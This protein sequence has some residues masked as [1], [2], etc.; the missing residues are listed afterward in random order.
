MWEW[1][2]SEITQ[3]KEKL[4]SLS[5]NQAKN[6][7]YEYIIDSI[8]IDK[9]SGELQIGKLIKN[10]PETKKSV[11]RFFINQIEIRQIDGDGTVGIGLTEK[12]DGG[13]KSSK[14]IKPE[15]A[16]GKV[17]KI[18]DEIMEAWETDEI[19]LFFQKVATNEEVL[20]KVWNYYNDISKYDWYPFLENQL[21]ESYQHSI[22]RNIAQ[23]GQFQ[24]PQLCEGFAQAIR[25]ESRTM[26]LIYVLL[27]HF[28]PNYSL[29][30]SGVKNNKQTPVIEWPQKLTP[31]FVFE[32]IKQSYQLKYLPQQILKLS[33]Y[34]HFIVDTFQSRMY[35]FIDST[36]DQYIL[37]QI[38]AQMVQF[39][40]SL[41]P[42]L[43]KAEF[44]FSLDAE[45]KADFIAQ[46]I[47]GS[48]VVPI[49]LLLY[50]IYHW[51]SCPVVN[52]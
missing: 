13:K 34:P 4:I 5:R 29:N 46:L 50:T 43:P 38:A 16:Q 15:E 28:F 47:W 27:F 52:E 6:N 49:H 25:A 40:S 23:T 31:E 18:Y 42:T 22:M 21:L 33:D 17:K 8:K 45:E 36:K 3:I 44:I 37:E 24:I 12:G 10:E 7:V 9:V 30:S 14:L 20:E 11:H 48:Q 35:P 1:I 26:I 2:Y 32:F 39:I 19:P 41:Y 51:L